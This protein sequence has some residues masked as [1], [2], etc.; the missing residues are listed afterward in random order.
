MEVTTEK[1]E[2]NTKMQLVLSK[3]LKNKRQ[4]HI[5][6]QLSME[7]LKTVKIFEKFFF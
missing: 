5:I 4:N 2:A 1:S 3:F 6:L 7:T